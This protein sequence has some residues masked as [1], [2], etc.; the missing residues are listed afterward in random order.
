MYLFKPLKHVKIQKLSK[1]SSDADPD[2]W[3][4]KCLIKV[5]SR[6]VWR[7][8]NPD[9]GHYCKCAETCHGKNS[10]NFFNLKLLLHFYRHDPRTS[11]ICCAQVCALFCFSLSSVCLAGTRVCSSASRSP[12]PFTSSLGIQTA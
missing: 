7:D 2:L 5:G 8:T 1:S 12:F 4:R 6:S 10:N 11:S 9:P 3:I